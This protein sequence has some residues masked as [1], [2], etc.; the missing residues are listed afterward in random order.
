MEIEKSEV[1]VYVRKVTGNK[2]WIRNKY[3]MRIFLRRCK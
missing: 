1:E 2:E 3:K